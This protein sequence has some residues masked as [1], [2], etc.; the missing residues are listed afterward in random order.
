M[1]LHQIIQVLPL[2][3][4][5]QFIL[6]LQK[7][8]KRSDT[9]NIDLFKLI[10]QDELT[11]NEI[12]AKLYGT[13]SKD[14]Y[15]ALRKRL[16]HSLIDFTA[17]SNLEEENS[18]DMQII[19]YILASRTLLTHKQ[20]KIAF[21][22][23]SKAETMA[24]EHSLFALLNEIYHTKIQYA[25]TNESEDI[26]ELIR[27]FKLNQEDV[28]L[29]DELNIVYAK[30]RQA[31]NEV[32]FKGEIV[33]FKTLVTSTLETH[34]I[35]ITDSMSFKSLYQ[36]MTILSMSAFVTND[37]YGL[38]PFLIDTYR[39]LLEKKDK[40]KQLYYHIQVLYLIANT[41]FRNKKF[42]MSLF[43]LNLMHG[44]MLYNRKKYYN[45]FKLK[46]NLLLALNHNYSNKPDIAISILEDFNLKKH[47]DI[48]A[49]LDIRL[50]LIMCYFQQSEF[51]KA[52]SIFSNFYHRDKW[53]EE[54][55][56]KEWVIKKNLI[57]ILLHLEL[58]N[59][60]LVESRLL[61]FKRQYYPYLRSIQQNRVIT[62]L[63]F[64]E[65]Y[66]KNPMSVKSVEFF[67]QVQ[68]S[69]EWIGA[70]REDIFVMSFYAWLKS[71]MEQKPIFEATMELVEKSQ[72]S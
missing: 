17:N 3:E 52:H 24:Q 53:Y 41:L 6:Y 46:Y 2:E 40:G 63:K 49:L 64:V 11:S 16:H 29:E 59:I 66:Y 20:Y 58:G 61:S 9:K 21:K 14:A 45:N 23:L 31:F 51:K 22:V 27:K 5:R 67:D 43:Y 56:G 48:E 62:Y 33:D 37:F 1:S 15:H 34:N 68:T 36:L 65:H 4:Q 72:K 38:E 32:T 10:S 28:F 57:E 55:A 30:I 54:K 26:N 44:Q 39:T 13:K 19:K 47:N 18:I 35:T 71:K 42:A 60:D 7:K 69:F 50:S 8:N 25:Y 12:C 70:K